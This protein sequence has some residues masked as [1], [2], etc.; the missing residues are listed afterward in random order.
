MEC[1]VDDLFSVWFIP[2]RTEGSLA[3]TLRTLLFFTTLMILLPIGLYFS[4]K[5]YVF[6]GNCLFKEFS[7]SSFLKE[8]DE[9]KFQKGGHVRWLKK[10]LPLILFQKVNSPCRLDQAD[11]VLVSVSKAASHMLRAKNPFTLTLWLTA[12]SMLMFWSYL[13]DREGRC[14]ATGLNCLSAMT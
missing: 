2:C 14:S 3:A 1:L 13:Y 8:L 9:N 6:E 10:I 11:D 4:S 7:A 5:V 12:L